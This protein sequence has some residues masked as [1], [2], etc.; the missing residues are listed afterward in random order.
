MFPPRPN[1]RDVSVWTNLERKLA[2]F[3]E[4]SWAFKMFGP[5]YY[6]GRAHHEWMKMT[7]I[8]VMLWTSEVQNLK[9][10]LDWDVMIV[11]R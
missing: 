6:F 1:T 4:L 8:S 5:S 9:C 3:I 7:D 10:V 2:P 11:I